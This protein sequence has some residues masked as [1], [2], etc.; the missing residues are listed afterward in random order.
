MLYE[1]KVLQLLPSSDNLQYVI[2]TEAIFSAYLL[3]I[4]KG[5]ST[6]LRYEESHYV[7]MMLTSHY[8]LGFRTFAACVC[9]SGNLIGKS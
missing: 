4:C 2:A 7:H 8:R 3:I 6:I 5:D 9:G 1:G